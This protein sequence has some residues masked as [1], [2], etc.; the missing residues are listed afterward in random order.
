MILY[1][2]LPL[3]KHLSIVYVIVVLGVMLPSYKWP[4]P[5]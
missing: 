4:K 3:S 2:W 5:P 1:C